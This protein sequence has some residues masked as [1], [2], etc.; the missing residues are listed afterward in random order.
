M[1]SANSRLG[2][3]TELQMIILARR[4]ILN[5]IVDPCSR[6]HVENLVGWMPLYITDIVL[7]RLVA[8]GRLDCRYTGGKFR[9][10]PASRAGWADMPS[11][12]MLS[13]D[14]ADRSGRKKGGRK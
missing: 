1:L 3:D 5:G 2:G 6:S 11:S 7:R 8:E 9:Y 4:A 12:G 14:A 13:L 10:V